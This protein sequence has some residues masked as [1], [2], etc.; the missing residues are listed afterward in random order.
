MPRRD[1]L[2]TPEHCVFYEGALI[3]VRMLV[4]GGSII[5]DRRIHAYTYYH[6]ELEQHAIL[7][8]ENLPT[9]SYLDTGNRRE[10]SNPAHAQSLVTLTPAKPVKNWASD[11]AAPLAVDQAT[12]KPIWQW[13][14]N[15]A[16]VL[17]LLSNSA[18]VDL[19]LEP[20]LRL[21]TD[22]GWEVRPCQVEG[23]TH[24]FVIPPG[25]RTLKLISRA[26]RPSDTVGPYLDDRRNLGVLVGDMTI[27][28]GAERMA[29]TAHL[30]PIALSGWHE[31]ESSAS[32]RW[33]SGNAAL[34]V[35][36]SF[37]DGHF[38]T[39]QI[40]IVHAGPYIVAKPQA[41]PDASNQAGQANYAA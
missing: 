20:D 30:T 26:S 14:R 41:V 29:V 7:L 2:V 18:T 37:L 6:I 3:P 1:L 15:R 39:L 16:Y 27:D 32:F 23:Q 8:S 35:D 12:V 38:G 4:N 17:G 34:P 9:E 25:S 5:A 19:V 28:N 40:E 21:I 13:L 22:S 31:M 11:A 36:L 10:F 33:T 24:S